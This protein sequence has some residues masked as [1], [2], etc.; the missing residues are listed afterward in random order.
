MTSVVNLPKV[1][2]RFE[3]LDGTEVWKAPLLDIEFEDA[4]PIIAPQQDVIGANFGYDMLGVQPGRVQSALDTLRFTLR[5]DCG[6]AELDLRFSELRNKIYNIG[7]GN[8]FLL[9]SLGAE[10]RAEMRLINLPT[11]SVIATAQP[12][13]AKLLI[14][15]AQFRRQTP[16]LGAIQV[17]EE[18]PDAT[19]Y[20]FTVS[21]PGTMEAEDAIIT[22]VGAWGSSFVLN[23]LTNGM[24]VAS[25]RGG[26]G[27]NDGVEFNCGLNTVRYTDDAGVTWFPDY[28]NFAR[29]TGQGGSLMRFPRGTSNMQLVID[30]TPASTIVAIAFYAP[31][32][33]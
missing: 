24:R 27:A 31:Y 13:A 2:R 28:A 32:L 14:A 11:Y 5:A 4:Q 33:I 16:W 18:T 3:S 26:A 12:Q 19:T 6:A 29:K 30:G 7:L 20:T 10:L 1:L 22:L 21:N 8:G 9:D 15:D 17:T 23:N 25:T